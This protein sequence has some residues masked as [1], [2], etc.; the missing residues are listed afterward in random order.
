MMRAL[1]YVALLIGIA[2]TGMGAFGL[3]VPEQFEPF[4]AEAQRLNVFA[5][6]AI[7]VAIGVILMLAAGASRA[8]FLLGALGLLIALGGFVTPFMGAPLKQVLLRWWADGS[9]MAVRAW[10][11][12][13][14]AIGAFIVYATRPKRK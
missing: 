14:L 8:P 1:P 10:A 3:A 2:L 13:S 7:R 4:V 6:A 12:V 5:L 11:G 9:V